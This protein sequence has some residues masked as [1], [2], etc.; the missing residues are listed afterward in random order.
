MTH[1]HI[2]SSELQMLPSMNH[3][4]QIHRQQLRSFMARSSY[5]SVL[6]STA[7]FLTTLSL[8]SSMV[9][10]LIIP[11]MTG[12]TIGLLL[13]ACALYFERSRLD[14]LLVH[15]EDRY[16]L[17]RLCGA[18]TILRLPLLTKTLNRLPIAG[19]VHIDMTALSLI[20]QTCIE[21]IMAWAEQHRQSGGSL[22]VDWGPLHAGFRKA[23]LKADRVQVDETPIHSIAAYRNAA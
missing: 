1:F 3:S 5:R 6:V 8:C 18:A 23:A 4:N 2:T 15:G 11:A 22:I 16:C 13:L 21:S 10:A 12:M 7:M 19:D 9:A 17:V 20:D 14:V